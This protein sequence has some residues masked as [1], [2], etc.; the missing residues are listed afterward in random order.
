MVP[1]DKYYLM[2]EMFATRP[3]LLINEELANPALQSTIQ[4]RHF[5]EEMGYRFEMS[6]EE[7][8]EAYEISMDVETVLLFYTIG[9][10]IILIAVIVPITRIVKLSPKKVLL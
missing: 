5:L 7:M 10:G 3:I 9:L 4:E 6:H 2:Q 1:I 8:L